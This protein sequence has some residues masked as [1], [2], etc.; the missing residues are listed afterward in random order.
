MGEDLPQF[1]SNKIEAKC[2]EFKNTLVDEN[3]ALE[4]FNRSQDIFEASGLDLD[5]KQYKSESETEMLLAAY[6]AHNNSIQPT[7]NAS[8]D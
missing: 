1:N 5:K 8:A 6:R 7:A 4:V 3:S 2:D